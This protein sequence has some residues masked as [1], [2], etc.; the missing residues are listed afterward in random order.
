MEEKEKKEKYSFAFLICFIFHLSI[1][2]CIILETS[3]HNNL[4]L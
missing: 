2:K 3:I 4:G 1:I